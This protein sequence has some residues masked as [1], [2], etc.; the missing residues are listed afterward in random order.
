[1]IKEDII[2]KVM[3][4]L[5]TENL[6]PSSALFSITEQHLEHYMRLYAFYRAKISKSIIDTNSNKFKAQY[7]Y[8]RKLAGLSLLK[9]KLSRGAKATQCKEGIIY[10]IKNPAW[11]SD[12]K[13]GTTTN[14]KARLSGYQTYSPYRDYSV[15]YYDF[16]LDKRKLERSLL[17]NLSLSLTDEGEWVSN[18]KSK[19]IINL[20]RNTIPTLPTWN[21]SY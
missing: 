10:I 20:V 1:M 7:N 6:I 21:F 14:L 5:E 3:T 11:P 9:L 16:V 15:D 19:D 2:S 13:V 12:V 8:A 17:D 18:T 4:D